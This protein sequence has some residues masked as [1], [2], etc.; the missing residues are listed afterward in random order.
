MINKVTRLADIFEYIEEYQGIIFDLD[1][2]LYPESDYVRSGYREVA[3]VLNTV[4]QA[5]KRLWD[6]FT[7]GKSAI[8]CLLEDA[9]I[10]SD[11]LKQRCLEA[12]RFQTPAIT[13][14]QEVK[15]ILEKIKSDKA[16]LGIIT[17]GRPEGQR[18][19]IKALGLETYSTDIIITDELGGVRY[20][21]PCPLAFERMRQKWKIPYSKMVYIGDNPRKDFTAPEKLGMGAVWF[22]NAGGLYH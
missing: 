16:Y 22:W 10:Y 3:K 13:L 11:E 9:G 5:Q 18:A 7:V 2:T 19:K 15:E 21:K 4:P 1:D 6:Y 14:T 8:D 17:D 20:R 12:Y